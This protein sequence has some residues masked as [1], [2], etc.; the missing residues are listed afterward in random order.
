MKIEIPTPSRFGRFRLVFGWLTQSAFRRLEVVEFPWDNYYVV[1]RLGRRA[2]GS[3]GFVAVDGKRLERLEV[4][5]SSL[6]IIT[7]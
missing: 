5:L 7:T 2:P 1:V 3:G 4:A 6:G